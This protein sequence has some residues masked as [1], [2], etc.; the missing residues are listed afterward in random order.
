MPAPDV[1]TR[2]LAPLDATG[3]S[4]MVT[5]GLAAI[6]YGD[7]RLTND[8]DLVVR[9]S[10]GDAP[11]LVAAFPPPAYYTPPLEVISEEATRREHGHFNILDVE[12]SLRADIY[13]LGDDSLGRWAFERL[14]RVSIG[15]SSIAIAPIEYVILRKL[16]YF[17]MGGS[18]RHLTDVAAMIR[19]SGPLI[20]R[21]ALGDWIE[22]LGVQREWQRAAAVGTRER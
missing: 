2:L 12:S 8:V 6:V 5:G 20:D 9:L 1:H 17:R 19:I 13:C 7:P 18:D 11:R 22:E 16:E 4:Y 3:I 15:G 14:H 10:A 21:V